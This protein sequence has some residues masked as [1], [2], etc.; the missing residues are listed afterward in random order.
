MWQISVGMCGSPLCA[1]DASLTVAPRDRYRRYVKMRAVKSRF[2]DSS[3]WRELA[4]RESD[5]IVAT[6]A[7]SGT[8]WVQQILAQLIFDGDPDV[9][10][11]T[12]SPFLE[13]RRFKT[14]AEKLEL[15]E[16]Q[17]HR[18]FLK[19]HLP[20][21]AGP[22]FPKARHIYIARDG[23][24][25][26]WSFYNFHLTRDDAWYEEMN[27]FPDEPPIE[28]PTTGREYFRKW[29]ENDGRPW[30]PFWDNIR[31]WWDLRANERVLLLHFNDLKADMPGQIRRIAQFIDAPINESRWDAIVEHC[32][33]DWMKRN[34]ARLAPRGQR[35]KDPSK[36]FHRGTNMQW[37]DELTEEDSRWYEEIARKEL[38]SECAEWLA[39]GKR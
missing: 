18:R 29:V 39:T 1:V 31:S 25:V 37:R 24:D 13:E 23:R 22:F 9:D 14:T 12:I 26:A 32:T 15:L 17:T 16:K 34:A 19:T 21:D 6:Y 2:L 20:A 35:W 28:R 33:F 5:I 38:G 8:T 36:F 4:I 3:A 7:K 11:A 10:V 27:R 30:W